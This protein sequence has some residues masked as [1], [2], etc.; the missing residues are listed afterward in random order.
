M[1]IER[2]VGDE[3]IF[4]TESYTY[5]SGQTLLNAFPVERATE[6]AEYT[7]RYAPERSAE[8]RAL[9]RKNLFFGRK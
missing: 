2:N 1:T 3:P 7:V 4:E 5:V 9:L 6:D 8:E